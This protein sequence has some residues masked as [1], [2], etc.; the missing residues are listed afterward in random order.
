MKLLKTEWLKSGLKLAK[1]ISVA[2][3]Y[4]DANFSIPNP[5]TTLVYT[6]SS[7][8]DVSTLTK[9]LTELESLKENENII[10]VINAVKSFI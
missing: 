5:V 6:A 3:Q 10:K 2:F 9:I 8:N 7:K 4:V 1:S